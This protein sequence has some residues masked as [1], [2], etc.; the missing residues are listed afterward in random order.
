MTALK[1]GRPPRDDI[2]GAPPATPAAPQPSNADMLDQ[3]LLSGS[4][5]WQV[6]EAEE[7]PLRNEVAPASRSPSPLA[8][9]TSPP[10]PTKLARND[11]NFGA[12]ASL[13]PVAVESLSMIAGRWQGTFVTGTSEGTSVMTIDRDG[14]YTAVVTARRTE[15]FSGK[16]ELIDGALR[17]TG[18]QTRRTGTFALYGAGDVRTLQYRS[19]DGS[20]RAELTPIR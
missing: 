19:D 2:T 17:G 10:T 4:R 15:T 20:I 16:I 9:S 5:T 11:T 14:N 13:A 6:E 12:A 7:N 8:T 1:K 18:D 3:R